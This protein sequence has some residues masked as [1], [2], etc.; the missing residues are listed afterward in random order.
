M[1]ASLNFHHLYYFY[2]VAREGS[3]A[4][5]CEVLHLAQPTV[6]GQVK[7]LE[8]SLGE[9]LFARAGRNLV[10]TDVGRLVYG[11]AEEIFSVSREMLDA[12]EG[13]GPERPLRLTVGVVDALPKLVA[14]R[15]LEPALHLEDPVHLTCREGKLEA[16]LADLAIHGLDLVL[17]DSPAQPMVRI[18]AYN[19]L[20]GEC[21]VSVFAT[22][23]L[24]GRYQEGFPGSLEGAPFLLPMEGTALRPAL[25]RWFEAQGLRP[26]TVAE[27]EDAALLKAFGHAGV[28]LFAAPSAIEGEVREQYGV[29]VVG[30]LAEVQERFYAIAVERRLKH[31]AVV[32]ISRAARTTLF[33]QG[34]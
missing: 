20:L 7:K 10:L 8:R 15:I 2:I 29:E 33:P 30:R 19:H 14:Y 4:R 12:L 24:A 28:G 6:S 18:R 1:L 17:S 16:L 27:V 22:A 32:A 34:D 13:R 25:E 23:G 21:G 31:P 26:R 5:A 3:V 9:A 11:Y